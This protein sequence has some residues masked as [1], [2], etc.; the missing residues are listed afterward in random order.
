MWALERTNQMLIL[1]SPFILV[2]C[3]HE[4]QA[5][6]KCN[7]CMLFSEPWSF[8]MN[9]SH[10]EGFIGAVRCIDSPERNRSSPHLGD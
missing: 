5:F 2:V 4:V 10:S 7:I 8:R 6:F 3:V 9:V 1:G